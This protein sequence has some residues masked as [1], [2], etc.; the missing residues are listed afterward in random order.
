[1][2]YIDNN[3]LP[4]E[5]IMFRTKKSLIIFFFPIVWTIVAIFAYAYMHTSPLLSK[6]EWIPW[7]IAIIL[8]GNVW[9]DYMTS[10]FAVTNK[11]VMMRE[12]FFTR[13]ANQVRL[14]TISQVNVNQSLLGQLFNFGVVSINTFGAF[15]S[16]S[17]I[18][19]PFQFQSMV[20]GQLD[21]AVQSESSR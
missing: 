11:R 15:D 4:D 17:M 20:N 3:I 16:Y 13:R 19:K 2:S 5:T 9:L 10:E 12:G 8:M 7:V 1:M 18:S 6:L 21:K 14:S